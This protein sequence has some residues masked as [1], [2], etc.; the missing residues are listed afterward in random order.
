MRYTP[1][2]FPVSFPMTAIYEDTPPRPNSPFVMPGTYKVKLTADGKSYE[3]E[4]K[5][6]MDPRVKTSKKDIRLQFDLSMKCY[7]NIKKCMSAMTQDDNGNKERERDLNRIMRTF[8]YLQGMLQQSDMPP[9]RQMIDGVKDAEK[10]LSK[11]L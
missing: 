11:I 4:F 8:S 9:T 10:E 7:E 1:L 3:K 6:K 5:I 2:D